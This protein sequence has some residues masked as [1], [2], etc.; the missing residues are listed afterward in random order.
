MPAPWSSSSTG[1]STDTGPAGN[2]C[3]TPSAHP[4]VEL[5]SLRTSGEGLLLGADAGRRPSPTGRAQACHGDSALLIV[6][7]VT[8]GGRAVS[9][10][11][12]HR[13]EDQDDEHT[14]A[15]K[16]GDHGPVRVAAEAAE[17]EA[18]RRG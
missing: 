10:C 6:V 15:S 7:S 16:G 11:R 8:A 14:A 2:P 3:G 13:Q 4:R 5:G 18:T 12:S 1:T 17:P 9:S